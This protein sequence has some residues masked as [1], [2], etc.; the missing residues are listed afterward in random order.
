[1]ININ[2]INIMI[3]IIII[4]IITEVLRK[5]LLDL[6]SEREQSIASR[7]YNELSTWARVQG[8]I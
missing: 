2:H 3:I 4:V 8:E 1:M 6:D 5:Q 7:R